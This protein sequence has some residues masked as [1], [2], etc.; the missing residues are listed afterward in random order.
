MGPHVTVRWLEQGRHKNQG[1]LQKD[2]LIHPT[3]WT[4]TTW[5]K[6]V[7]CY[8]TPSRSIPLFSQPSNIFH[9]ARTV[10][11][12]TIY[13]CIFNCIFLVG[14]HKEIGIING[15][16]RLPVFFTLD[17]TLSTKE[18]YR[19]S[20]EGPASHARHECAIVTDLRPACT[21]VTKSPVTDTKHGWRLLFVTLCCE[22]YLI[23]TVAW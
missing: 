2:N 6:R 11:Y 13:N 21:V 17:W 23:F 16:V 15:S 18:T 3:T 4:K 19:L 12:G 5:N 22:N 1:N 20:S 8:G 9:I 10:R 7:K 14:E